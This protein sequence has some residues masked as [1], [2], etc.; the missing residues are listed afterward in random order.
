MALS[1]VDENDSRAALRQL[2]AASSIKDFCK[3]NGFSTST[4]HK[5][6]KQGR[7]PRELRLGRAI[8]ITAQ[9]AEEWLRAREYPEDAEARLLAKEAEARSKLARKAG[10]KAA[11]SEHHVAKVRASKPK[12][13]R[14]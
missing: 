8:R 13:K 1:R 5:L 7:G 9:A 3:H 6:K 12:N 2:P 4:Y 11:Q 14:A 10:K